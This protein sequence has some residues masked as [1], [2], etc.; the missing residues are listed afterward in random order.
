MEVALDLH[1]SQGHL[2]ML[3][4]LNS[5][6]GHKWTYLTH[7][8]GL[9]EDPLASPFTRSVQDLMDVASKT[10]EVADHWLANVLW[11]AA[12][13]PVATAITF[14]G[15]VLDSELS[16]PAKIGISFAIQLVAAEANSVLSY[17][18]TG[19]KPHK[20][21][22]AANNA[23]NAYGNLRKEYYELGGFLVRTFLEGQEHDQRQAQQIANALQIDILR[24]RVTA[25]SFTGIENAD[26]I[27]NPLDDAVRFIR[28]PEGA[29]DFLTD[30]IQTTVELVQGKRERRQLQVQVENLQ[31]QV[32]I[33]HSQVQRLLDSPAPK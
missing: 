30:T 15:V 14:I 26:D 27:V 33:L 6:S 4:D 18:A 3:T 12:G 17:Y 13:A 8:S 1:S 22:Q 28:N 7:L 10:D 5:N 24:A 2:P 21:S 29:H 23:Q 20:A 11:V 19:I 9:H 25:R 16:P 31:A 32:A